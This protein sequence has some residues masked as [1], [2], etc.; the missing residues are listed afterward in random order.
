MPE[1]RGSFQGGDRR[2]AVVVARFNEF[3]T[4]RLLSG[5]L[6]AFRDHGVTDE[7]LG[8]VEQRPGRI[9][10]DPPQCRAFLHVAGAGAGGVR[11]DDVDLLAAHL[12][13]RALLHSARNGLTA[14]GFVPSFVPLLARA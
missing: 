5:A 8:V 10:K 2:F 4:E 14:G 9:V 13:A 1:Y 11:A 6:Q 12:S 7:A 3:I